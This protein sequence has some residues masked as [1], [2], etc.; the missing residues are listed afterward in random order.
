[1]LELTT[2]PTN[3][4]HF[5]ELWTFCEE[6]LSICHRL[7]VEPVMNASLAVLAY[8]KSTELEVH[9]VDLSCPESAFPGLVAAC[10]EAGIDAEVT[11]WHVLE[12]HR[13]ELKVEFD[14][15]EH[16]MQGLRG[17]TDVFVH[18]DGRVLVVCREDLVTLYERGV[19]AFE[20]KTELSAAGEERLLDLRRKAALARGA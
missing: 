3:R 13:G 1:M 18:G 6:V 4:A 20:A 19:A 16:W 17:D 11:E 7:D 8:S 14:G 5:D 15:A 12:L 10:T 2:L 9:D